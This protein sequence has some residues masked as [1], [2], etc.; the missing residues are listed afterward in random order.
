[1]C[2]SPPPPDEPGV[3]ILLVDD[4]P[5]K[6]LSMQTIL[7][8]LN[9]RIVTAR[10]GRDALRQLLNDDFAVILLDVNMPDMDGFETACLIRQRKRSEHTP[11]IFVTAMSDDNHQAHGYSLGAVDYILAPVHPE[12][13]RTKV[14][15]FVD[16][17]RKRKEAER[18]AEE[19]LALALSESAR[20]EAERASQAK[21][22]FLANL[23]H[24]LRTPMNSIVGMTD[25]AL[26][27]ELPTTARDYLQT[28]RAS[29]ELLLALLNE[30]L[31]FSRIE[32][33][34]FT[35]QS[36]P[37]DLRQAVQQTV[38]SLAFQAVDKGLKVEFEFPVAL[39]TNVVGDS[40]RLRQILTNLLANAIKFTSTGRVRVHVQTLASPTDQGAFRFSVIDT[41][42]GIS[43]ADQKRIFS[44]FTQVDSSA[45]RRF[46]GTGLGLAIASN[47]V[48]MMGGQLQVRSR[49]QEGSTFWFDL[50]FPL[51]EMTENR[52]TI[53][54]LTR[55]LEPNGPQLRILLA[56]DTPANQK[57]MT[58][59]LLKHGHHVTVVTNG[60]EAVESVQKESFDLVLM[61][62]QMPV[63][64]GLQATAAI[65]ALPSPGPCNIPIIALTAHAMQGDESR[66]L[67][68]GMD[69]YLAKPIDIAQLLQVTSEVFRRK[70]TT[71]EETSMHAIE[72]K[73]HAM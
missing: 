47:L 23:S 62:I 25:L 3:G 22:E 7:E 14:S 34:Q 59:V 36:N 58:T 10:S 50:T 73:S 42:I 40:L 8:N 32:S 35:L 70:R 68:A 29:A 51:D 67:E 27:E 64:S 56:E 20:L 45:T 60:L 2:S 28:A 12:V 16:L 57:L 49:E 30:I 4:S 6:L 48:S 31:D 63:M 9:E 33:G 66:C 46:G 1:M 19:Q 24:E 52:E 43:A 37:F 21:S 11:I 41:G 54:P 15:V 39:T 71:S 72:Q 53:T 55:N 17:F 13:L 26:Q 38:H 61:D 18:R 65:R 5:D 44:P 69:A